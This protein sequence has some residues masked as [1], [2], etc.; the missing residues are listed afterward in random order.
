M[1]TCIDAQVITRFAGTGTSGYSGYG[2]PATA[3][4]LAS[5]YATAADGSGNVYI[6][7]IGNNRV[8]KVAASGI[9]TTIAGNGSVFSSGSDGGLATA[10]GINGPRG[11]A[12]DRTGNVYISDG[13]GR[14]RKINTLGIITTIAGTGTYGFSGDGGPATAAEMQPVEGIAVDTLGNVYIADCGNNR[15]RKITTS[16]TI[17]T[18]AGNGIAGYSGYGGPA[19]A[20]ELSHPLGIAVAENGNIYIADYG[21][22]RIEKLVQSTGVITTVAG[23]GTTGSS[24]LA[25][26]GVLATD[27]E[28]WNPIAVA[29]SRTGNLY[30]AAA[31]TMAI[32]QVNT[33]GL[34]TTVA[35]NG[36]YGYTGENGSAT[37]AEITPP[38]GVAVDISGNVY[39]T[40][41]DGSRVRKVNDTS[42]MAQSF[43]VVK[44]SL[45]S[46]QTIIGYSH[47]V[48]KKIGSWVITNL[49]PSDTLRLKKLT[50]GMVSAGIIGFS[51]PNWCVSNLSVCP[52]RTIGSVPIRNLITVTDIILPMSSVTVDV[53]AGFNH[54][55]VSFKLTLQVDAL[56]PSGS[57]SSGAIDGQQIN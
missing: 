45:Y 49:S 48:N 23:N 42:Y 25:G 17:T 26:D 54:T 40:S 8:L 35:G 31:G 11:V 1:T 14:I 28:I 56:Y 36:I 19:T 47:E 5:P 10:T 6:T 4:E 44:N 41:P 9:I 52:G 37:A 20:A 22:N 15:I 18:I 53:Y 50:T 30:I 38:Y 12:V 55:D 21:N 29:I 51:N 32:R 43:T 57:V 39:F 3:A 34:L 2:G 24:I 13:N 33:V 27:A 46:D 16:G 7:D